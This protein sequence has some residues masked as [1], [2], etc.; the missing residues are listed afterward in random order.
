MT[1]RFFP[2]VLFCVFLLVKGAGAAP[3]SDDLEHGFT[4]LPGQTKPWVYWYWISDH[5]SREGITK[6][7]E[8]MRRAGIGE[9]LIG[10]IFL[11]GI[12][13]GKVKV[14]TDRWWG[15][16]MHAISEGKRLGVNIGMFNCP[17]WSQ[18]GGPWIKPSQAMRYL[19][20]SEVKVRGP[21]RMKQKLPRPAEE[22]QD[23]SV[24]A[25]PVPTVDTDAVAGSG[26]AVLSRPALE[27]AALLFDGSLDTAC[28]FPGNAS[29]ATFTI[30]TEKMRTVR[31]LSV[32]PAKKPFKAMCR[33]LVQK[34]DGAWQMI[35]T[36]EVDRSNMSIN[37]G[38]MPQGPVTVAFPALTASSFRIEF[39][40]LRRNSALAELQLSAAARL[41]RFVEKQ[42]G[43]MHPTP[44]PLWDTYLWPEPKEPE[45]PRLVIEPERVVDV[46]DRLG[47]D[48]S[49]EWNVPPGEWIILRT[50]MTPTG[51]ENAPASPEGKGLEVDKMNRKAARDHFDAFI[52]KV[53]ARVPREKRTA[54]TRVVADSY[55]MGSQNWTDGFAALFGKQYGYDPRLWLAVLTGRMVGS[56]E[57]SERFL[58]DLRRLVADRIAED[59]VG[60]LR[61]ICEEHDLQLWLENYGHWGFPGE[62]LKYGGR[63]NRI[64]GE[65]W[66]TGSLGSIE[67]R[68]ASS[69][70]NTYG[71][72]V[73]SAEA[74]TGGPAFQTAPWGLKARGDWAFCEGINHFVLHV[75]I[76]Q[77]GGTYPPGINA[78]FGTEFNRRN[79][80]FDQSRAW[81][82]YLRRCC[83]L[84]Q[85][86]SRVAD[87]AYF[88]GEDT[89]KM[90]GVRK[91]ALPMGRDFDYINAEVLLTKARGENGALVLLHG[92]RY[93]LLVLPDLPAM[94]PQLLEKIAGLVREGAVVFGR[95][96]VR[97]PS[98]KGYPA[99]DEKVRR[100][101][102]NLWGST[103]VS[104]KGSRKAGKGRVVWGGTLEE[105]FASAGIPADF[106]PSVPLRFTHR[107]IDGGDI[108]FVANPS[109][110]PVRSTV[111]FR[112]QG[113]IPELWDPKTG[114]RTQAVVYSEADGVTKVSLCLYGHQS[115][116]VVFRKD[117][118]DGDDPVVS[119]ARNGTELLAAGATKERK[120]S[121]IFETD[122]AEVKDNFTLSFWVKPS[123][124]TPL[125]GQ[126]DRG[127][128]GLGAG[129]NDVIVPPHGNT[130]SQ[131]GRH[132]GCGVSVGT[133]G[134][135]VFEHGA[136]YFAPILV[137]RCEIKGWTH[138]AL[139]YRAGRPELYLNGKNVQTGLQSRY[140]VHPGMDKNA[141]F[142]GRV[143]RCVVVADALSD[144]L[145]VRLQ[146]EMRRPV[147]ELTLPLL[148]L[149]QCSDGKCE[150]EVFRSGVY[151]IRTEKGRTVQATVD[152]IPESVAL[153]GA[154]DVIPLAAASKKTGPSAEKGGAI[155]MNELCDW[156]D[157]PEL[158]HYAGTVLYRKEFFMTEIPGG[159]RFYLDLGEVRDIAQVKINGR[160]GSRT[161]ILWMK[162][163]RM[164]VT[165]LL[166][167]GIN[168]LT[169]RV[170]N[171]WNNRL[172]HDAA[173][174]REKRTTW[175]AAQT[176]D[177]NA[178]LLPA[179]LLGPVS[180][181]ISRVVF[182]K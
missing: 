162:P 114:G 128:V 51:T 91:P 135:C 102:E 157:R 139:V 130:F 153:L 30:T 174:P 168:I 107:R 70:A 108:Y 12:T 92:T 122:A 164:E 14:L 119:V 169:V 101:A 49:F 170:T 99:C 106:A 39:T 112:V 8:A 180:I 2:G 17:G 41:E 86:G 38:P 45:S 117:R 67:C 182:V 159:C 88:I 24:L 31:S 25:F 110:E 181:R 126:Q 64:G 4:H 137:A 146:K 74:F 26:V 111:S 66:V 62:F 171:V 21:K 55:E 140:H 57:Q 68:A 46:T 151:T 98:L 155:V 165:S 123:G 23:V 95:P 125:F 156:R 43:K 13:P 179:G 34:A 75:Y 154:W 124:T 176:V 82:E 5:I 9:V 71:M 105:Y 59:Y 28:S 84:L 173:L 79:T 129:R 83:H 118:V 3:A 16:V 121:F 175:L 147:D 141:Q 161:G 44:L 93:K 27:G 109:N 178:P 116:F 138:A 11:D 144:K 56:A 94:R 63:S 7:L 132:A 96:P 32:Y 1:T 113:R 19:V 47:E 167:E 131:E 103:E 136:G 20:S 42:L 150:V 134:I 127:I 77:P 104:D 29:N 65:F 163:W 22:F 172:V 35:R 37:V 18:S 36:F 80:W 53:L 87:V 50:G 90:T 115:L 166:K 177:K 97:S 58:W 81:I 33:L 72:P 100:L 89:P 73:V 133:N 76:H 60:G 52:G 145:I 143:G 6:D 69:A 10:N 142:R 48:G 149:G 15:M 85:Q 61:E 78:W 54:F 40:H 120:S 160:S 152:S 148:S 158:K